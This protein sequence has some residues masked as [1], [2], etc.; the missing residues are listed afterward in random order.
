M[1]M[2]GNIPATLVQAPYMTRFGFP[3]LYG[4]LNELKFK[5]NTSPG[6]P[7]T[8]IISG[9]GVDLACEG[10]M[11]VASSSFSFKHPNF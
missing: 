1:K 2:A 10:L 4:N 8:T 3:G 11:S 6:L 7:R 5:L 9:Q